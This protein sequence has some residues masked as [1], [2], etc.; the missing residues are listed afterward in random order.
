MNPTI[1]ALR[2]IGTEFAW[3]IYKPLLILVGSI[4]IVLVGIS[5]WLTTISAWWWILCIL[6]FIILLVAAFIFTAIGMLISTIRPAQNKAQ[7]MQVKKFVDTIQTVADV[8]STPKSVILF[9]IIRDLISKR[10]DSY[11]RR[12][13]SETLA[14]QH[15]FRDIIDSYK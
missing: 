2:A 11:T 3:R 5:I 12:I 8:A 7:A 14:M 4:I 1:K 15:D 6:F 10:E 13:S 9:R